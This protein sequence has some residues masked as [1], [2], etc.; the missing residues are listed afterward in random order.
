MIVLL[1]AL[2]S[3]ALADT[4]RWQGEADDP[5]THTDGRYL[6]SSLPL[7]NRRSRAGL[8]VHHAVGDSVRIGLGFG[9]SGAS[10]RQIDAT[11]QFLLDDASVVG[12]HV[13]ESSPP[14]Q[15]FDPFTTVMG[16]V[17][18][19]RTHLAVGLL[20]VDDARKL[21]SGTITSIRHEL[22]NSGATTFKVAASDSRALAAALAC[23][24]GP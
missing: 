23:A 22:F 12:L 7:N 18:I 10:I 17:G 11:V 8:N 20:T 13:V 16:V 5:F 24:I 1:A 2:L 4:C 19:R 9:E 21:A 6:A 15:A 3:P 14:T